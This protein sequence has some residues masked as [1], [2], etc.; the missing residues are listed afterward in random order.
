MCIRQKK[1]GYAG[2][3]LVFFERNLLSNTIGT[4]MM[5][6]LNILSASNYCKKFVTQF[7][8]SVAKIRKP[9]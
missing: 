5:S 7:F 9:I 2:T 1:R 6:S 3:M 8:V 4:S